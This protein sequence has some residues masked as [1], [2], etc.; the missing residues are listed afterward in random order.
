[1]SRG[2]KGRKQQKYKKGVE[3]KMVGKKWKWEA[4]GL[5]SARRAK[6]ILLSYIS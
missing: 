2:E 3:Q 5:S 4:K 6:K 1:M